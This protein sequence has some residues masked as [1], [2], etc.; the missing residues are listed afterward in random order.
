MLEKRVV[1]LEEQVKTLKEKNEI[2]IE[3][4]I[5]P[6]N[7]NLKDWDNFIRRLIYGKPSTPLEKRLEEEKNIKR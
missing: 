2:T 7:R 6:M 1:K 5:N 4:G 3:Y